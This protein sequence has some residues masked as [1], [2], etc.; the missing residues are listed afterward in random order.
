MPSTD[1]RGGGRGPPG[2]DPTEVL[3]A[4]ELGGDPHRTSSM[5][6]EPIAQLATRHL[7]LETPD[8]ELLQ[9]CFVRT[10]VREL[11]APLPYLV[12]PP[13]PLPLPCPEVLPPSI[14]LA[15]CAAVDAEEAVGAPAPAPL[16][17]PGRAALLASLQRALLLGR[18]LPAAAT[19]LPDEEWR[20]ALAETSSFGG[21]LS[22]EHLCRLSRRAARL[23]APRCAPCERPPRWP[24]A[25]S[26]ASRRWPSGWSST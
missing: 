5:Q 11:V 20:A 22:P 17:P 12:D 14:V 18:E 4:F 25:G 13:P 6:Q 2:R 19:A 9:F 26:F 24:A 15:A 21:G 7:Y 8:S 1:C 10:P 16:D 3:L 23:R